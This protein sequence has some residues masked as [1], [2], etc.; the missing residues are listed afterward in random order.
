MAAVTRMVE[1][2]MTAVL[3]ATLTVGSESLEPF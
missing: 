1:C 2:L 3:A